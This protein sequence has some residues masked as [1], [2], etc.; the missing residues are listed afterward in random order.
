MVIAGDVV[1]SGEVIVSGEVVVSREVALAREMVIT[2][3]I[4]SCSSGHRA[5][6]RHPHP[7]PPQGHRA[8]RG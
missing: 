1:V 7:C 3:E 2:G 4:V 5:L 8:S 6:T